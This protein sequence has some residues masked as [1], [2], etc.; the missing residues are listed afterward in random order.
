MNYG[1]Y[2]HPLLA[3]DQE[4]RLHA[5]WERPDN[6]I[7]YARSLDN[8]DHWQDLAIIADGSWSSYLTTYSKGVFVVYQMGN[9]IRGRLSTDFGSP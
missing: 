9:E 8:G 7:W 2:R 1:D 5:I 3:V 4:N 6:Y